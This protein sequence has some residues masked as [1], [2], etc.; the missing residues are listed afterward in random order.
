M[1]YHKSDALPITISRQEEIYAFAK[2]QARHAIRRGSPLGLTAL[3]LAYY[4]KYQSEKP[5]V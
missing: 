5:N 2:A 1:A 4:L 3:G